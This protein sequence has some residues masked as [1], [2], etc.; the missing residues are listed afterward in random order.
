MAVS[1]A[2]PA[3]NHLKH[4]AINLSYPLR[5]IQFL[6]LYSTISFPSCTIPDGF[7]YS[8]M[9]SALYA[10]KQIHQKITDPYEWMR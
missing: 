3:K 6:Y 9:L 4:I 7:L 10:I 2:G 5:R 8:D 1:R